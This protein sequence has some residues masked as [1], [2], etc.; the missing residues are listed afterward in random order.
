MVTAVSLLYLAARS[1]CIF[2]MLWSC[3]CCIGNELLA[4]G[5]CRVWRWC[6]LDL[7]N[8]VTGKKWVKELSQPENRIA[9]NDYRSCFSWLV[10]LPLSCSHLSVHYGSRVDIFIKCQT[11]VL[12]L[13][14]LSIDLKCIIPFYCALCLQIELLLLDHSDPYSCLFFI[15][16]LFCFPMWWL[17][18]SQQV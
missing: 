10:S 3:L 12:R 8:S 7:I 11:V 6:P 15:F 9:V 18:V 17:F 5:G 4:Y 1:R 16:S 14:N 13:F 2:R